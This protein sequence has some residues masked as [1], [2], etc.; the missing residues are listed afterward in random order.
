MTRYMARAQ[1]KPA[2]FPHRVEMIVPKGGFGKRLHAM[3]EWQRAR[4]RS[5]KPRLGH[6][7]RDKNNRD[8]VTWCFG[9]AAMAG[10]FRALFVRS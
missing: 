1:T 3:H 4:A 7:W 5:I 9:D 10:G 2:E 6:G 8:Y